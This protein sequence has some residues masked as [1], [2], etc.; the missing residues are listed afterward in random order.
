MG[1][2]T[3]VFI[4]Q[5]LCDFPCFVQRSE[6]VKIQYFCPV[7]PVKPFDKGILGRLTRFDKVQHHPVFFRPLRQC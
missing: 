1:P 7:R 4:Q 5:A 2:L 3:V 6:Q